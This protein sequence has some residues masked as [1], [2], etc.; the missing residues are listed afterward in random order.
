M[1]VSKKINSI[2]VPASGDLSSYQFRAMYAASDGEATPL[3]TGTVLTNPPIGI[4]LNKPAG[5]ARAAEIAITGSVVKMEAA[6]A[7]DEGELITPTTGGRGTPISS[8]TAWAVGVALDAA[9][10]SAAN[11]ALLV[12]PTWVTKD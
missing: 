9:S 7:V 4:L 11:F 5:T 2:T 3:T 10:G 6:G 1:T 12:Q 8:G